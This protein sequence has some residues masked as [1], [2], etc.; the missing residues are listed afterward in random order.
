MPKSDKADSLPEAEKIFK[1]L[2]PLEQWPALA[3]S[4]Q[5]VFGF[6]YWGAC[7]EEPGHNRSSSP[8]TTLADI[9]ERKVVSTGAGQPNYWQRHDSEPMHIV[10]KFGVLNYTVKKCSNFVAA[11]WGAMKP[12]AD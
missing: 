4:W 2:R 6:L 8:F 12:L 11:L 7:P 5:S 9:A 3:A 1:D 10:L